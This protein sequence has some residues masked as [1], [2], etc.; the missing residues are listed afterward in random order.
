MRRSILI[1][2]AAVLIVGA[3]FWASPYFAIAGLRNALIQNDTSELEERVDFPRLR[4]N[5]K[6]Q[7]STFMMAGMK[8]QLKDN[9]FAALGLALA[10]KLTDVMVDSM[11][12]PA[13]M[14]TLMDLKTDGASETSGFALMTSSEF[15]IRRDGLDGFELQTAKDGDQMP[16][17]RFKRDGIGWRLV[18]LQMPKELLEARTRNAG[19]GREAAAPQASTW[20]FTESK[21]PMDDSVSVLLYREAD[22]EVGSGFSKIRPTMVLRCEGKKLQ[23]YINFKGTVDYNYQ[24]D[25]SAV[26]LRFDDKTAK[27][28]GWSISTS[29][30]ALFAPNP[31]TFLRNLLDSKVLLVEWRQLGE[32][33]NV[34]RFTSD[35]LKAHVGKFTAACGIANI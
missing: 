32:K 35:D 23:A 30:E 25:L 6:M 33:T 16:T 34:A 13:G 31:R 7:M 8:E 11:V 21:D 20:Q 1:T 29:R 19:A 5:V 17:F 26:R 9:P 2:I 3:W 27:L 24:T 14:L 15:A 22:E 12:T 18:G 10:T 28:E 4:E